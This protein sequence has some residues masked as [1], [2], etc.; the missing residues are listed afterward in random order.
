[1]V[2]IIEIRDACSGGKDV[3]FDESVIINMGVRVM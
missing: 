2:I 3:R 1:M